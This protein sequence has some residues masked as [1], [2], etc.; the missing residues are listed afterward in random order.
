[1]ARWQSWK[2]VAYGACRAARDRL[3]SARLNSLIAT[4]EAFWCY[5]LLGERF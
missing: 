5:R 2:L 4:K 1:M 3:F